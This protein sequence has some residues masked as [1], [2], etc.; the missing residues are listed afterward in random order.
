M[1]LNFWRG[2]TLAFLSLSFIFC[3]KASAVDAASLYLNP[4]SG[5][6]KAGASFS[7]TLFVESSGAAMNGVSA[8]ISFPSDL[9]RVTSISKAGSIVNLWAS[10][11]EFSNDGGS[12]KLEGVVLNG[13]TGSS[14]KIVTINFNTKTAGS[15]PVTLQSGSILAHDGSGT[16]ILTSSRSAQFTINAQAEAPVVEEKEVP[17]KETEKQSTAPL[18]APGSATITSLTHPSSDGW[19]S[20]HNVK[21]AWKLNN[22]ISEVR[23]VLDKN[24][25]TV[26]TETDSAISKKEYTNVSDGTWYFHLRLSNGNEWGAVSRKR[27]QIDSVEPETFTATE[28]ERA[29]QTNPVVQYA[30]DGSD[31]LSGLSHV[32]VKIGNGEPIHWDYATDAVFASP[33]LSPGNHVVT[34]KLFDKAGNYTMLSKDLRIEP[35]KSPIFTEYE[36]VISSEAIMVVK[37]ESIYPNANV[38]VYYQKAQGK[39]KQQNMQTDQNGQFAF[40]PDESLPNG[41]YSLWAEVSDAR[42]AR[43]L[44]SE[45]ITVTVKMPTLFRLLGIDFD[46]ITIFITLLGI[47]ILLAIL[48][49]WKVLKSHREIK[50]VLSNVGGVELMLHKTFATLKDEIKDQ[51]ATLDGTTNLSEREKKIYKNLTNAVNRAEKYAIE[52]VIEISTKAKKVS[53]KKL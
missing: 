9:L 44:P 35:L 20:L 39:V 28:I 51:L 18:G 6:Y 41:Y 48:L 46:Y 45:T 4:S 17:V 22:N 49:M 12:I 8:N 33:I 10:E 26:P 19:Y 38:T 5:S 24:A 29:D 2:L 1:N 15:A 36:R 14:G 37:G 7:V 43:S 11:P 23:Y 25:K 21:L 31:N 3:F 40:I 30:F 16:N 27:I 52:D 47:I 13:Y 50:H 42:G 32:E 53:K 34:A